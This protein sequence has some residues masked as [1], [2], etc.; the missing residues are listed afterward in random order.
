M[1]EINLDDW[2]NAEECLP[3]EHWAEYANNHGKYDCY[4]EEVLIAYKAYPAAPIKIGIGRVKNHMWIDQNIHIIAW[5]P[6]KH[7]YRE[8]EVW[9]TDKR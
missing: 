1:L 4:S 7:E 9:D 2:V 5:M 8:F 6:L 3:E